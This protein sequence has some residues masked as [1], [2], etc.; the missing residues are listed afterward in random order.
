MLL[1]CPENSMDSCALRRR[2][3]KRW[4]VT[5]CFNTSQRALYSSASFLGSHTAQPTYYIG[6]RR[7]ALCFFVSSFSGSG[8]MMHTRRVHAFLASQCSKLQQSCLCIEFQN[9]SKSTRAE[10][11][12]AGQA[13]ARIVALCPVRLFR[14]A[15]AG[16]P[17]SR[18]GCFP[19]N[20]PIYPGLQEQTK[21]ILTPV[22]KAVPPPRAMYIRYIHMYICT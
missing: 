18:V 7:L 13:G 3:P 10:A 15:P 1:A 2:N 4:L 22:Q 17:R 11:G 21:S 12:Q 16:Y 9:A 6:K 19:L 5:T 14:F 8:A 20:F